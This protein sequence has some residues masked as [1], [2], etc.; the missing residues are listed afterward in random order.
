[1]PTTFVS[2]TEITANV[3]IAPA[4]GEY[5]VEVQRGE[6]LSDVLVFSIV[7]AEEGPTRAARKEPQKP[8]PKKSEPA[9]K[10]GK[11]KGKR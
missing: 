10:R 9:H 8:K 11:Q 7:S 6:D 3:P 2:P 5:D 1:V 4:E